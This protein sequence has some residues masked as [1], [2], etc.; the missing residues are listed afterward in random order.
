LKEEDF[1]IIGMHCAS[2]ARL[3]E[4]NTGALPGVAGAFVNIA[5]KKLSLRYDPQTLCYEQLESAIKETGL[6]IYRVSADETL[7][8]REPAHTQLPWRLALAAIFSLPLFDCAMVPMLNMAYTLALPFPAALEPMHA[9]LPYAL[10]QL[11]LCLPVLFAGSGFY[12]NGLASILRFA[13]NMDALIAV[14]TSAAMLHSMHSL[15]LLIQGQDHA[16]EHLYFESVAVIITL[17]LFGRFLE[18]RSRQRS[19]A[20]IAR[21]AQLAPATAT[22]VRDGKEISM[23]LGEVRVGD[24]VRVRPGERI[25]VDGVI[26]EGGS[27]VDESMLT[28][29]SLP[30]ERRTG[31]RLIGASMNT[32]GAMLMRA[33]DIGEHSVLARI[34]RLI[35]EAQGNRPPIARLADTVSG[36]FVQAVFGI[37]LLAGGLWLLNGAEFAFALR[38]FTAVLVIACPC[39]LGLATPAALMVGIG[40]G[41]ELGILIKSGSVLEAAAKIDAV[42]LDKTGTLTEGKPFVRA[43]FPSSSLKEEDLLGISCALENVSEHP[44]AAAVLRYAAER[45]INPVRVDEFDAV[46]GQGVRGTID[47]DVCALGNARMMAACGID[48]LVLAPLTALA[49]PGHTLLFVARGKRLLGGI[50]VADSIKKSAPAAVAGLR[51]LGVDIIMLTGDTQSAAESIAK[52]AGIDKVVAE[53]LP[54]GKTE[55]IAKLQGLGKRVLM[56][57]DGI[58]DAPA[59]ALADVGMAVN[60][61]TDVAMESAD[62]VLMRADMLA[63]PAALQLSRATFRVI[64]QNLF[65][66]FCYNAIGIPVAA[67]ALHALF[68]GPLLNPMLAALAMALSSVSVVGNALRLRTFTPGC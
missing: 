45:G 7:A 2:C 19:S 32:T 55:E 36:Y 63:V 35:R 53:V 15:L 44:L 67:G 33:T 5:T 39:A 18:N 57:G 30:V 46:P 51:A 34:V 17:I 6:G 48:A 68:G 27:Y 42:M 28:G 60:S 13:P 61:G 25:P 1:I 43:V 24:L 47:G 50:A 23:T 3:V 52:D 12:S 9:P 56:V 49:D 66:A 40:R 65:W 59:L 62:I 31:E 26:V 64:R 10:V 8:I 41:A 20:A 14:G 58:N 4:R 29:E 54:S 38:I 21:L 37:A 22:V 16:V 11:G